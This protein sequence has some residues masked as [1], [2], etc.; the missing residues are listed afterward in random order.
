M[1]LVPDIVDALADSVR[2]S[3]GNGQDII[4]DRRRAEAEVGAFR[5]YQAGIA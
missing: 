1:H 3:G 5:R 4:G 2:N